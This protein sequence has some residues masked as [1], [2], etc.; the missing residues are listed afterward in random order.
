MIRL[1]GEQCKPLKLYKLIMHSIISIFIILFLLLQ[2][3]SR[4]TH[5]EETSISDLLIPEV[6]SLRSTAIEKQKL[7]KHYKEG[8]NLDEL[9]GP[10]D[11]FPFLPDNHRDSGTGKFNRF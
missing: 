6:P 7:D 2:P 5:A 10:K 4:G 8:R 3:L 1:N 9:L 11:I